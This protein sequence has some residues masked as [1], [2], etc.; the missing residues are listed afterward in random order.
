L[1]G[2][3]PLIEFMLL[4][5]WRVSK[6]E[7]TA[8]VTHAVLR[9]AVS[10]FATPKRALREDAPL[11]WVDLRLNVWQALCRAI[12]AI[13]N[14]VEP[15]CLLRVYIFGAT[16]LLFGLGIT[17]RIVAKTDRCESGKPELV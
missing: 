14:H 6:P 3:L 9:N 15:L 10:P 17:A 8:H 7:T 16:S 5:K 1:F 4:V 11:P 12:P 13:P 2:L